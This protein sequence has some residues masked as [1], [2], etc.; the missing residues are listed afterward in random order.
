MEN[1]QGTSKPMRK[2]QSD[3]VPPPRKPFAWPQADRVD[4]EIGCG[5]G[6]HPIAYA[7]AHPDRHIIALDRSAVRLE[8][9]RL[10]L[11]QQSPLTNLSVVR[12][13]ADRFLVHSVPAQS[14]QQIFL[15][16]PNP[17]PK[18]GQ[19]N[20]RWHRMPLMHRM[21]A[22]L[23]PS[24]TLV[25]ATNMPFYA[26]EA[27]HYMEKQWALEVQVDEVFRDTMPFA[28]RTHFEQKYLTRGDPIFHLVFQKSTIQMVEQP[29]D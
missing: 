27:K 9:M 17:Y 13:D 28:P 6:M 15:L 10:A 12:E 3:K 18:E 5:V 25:L 22:C 1:L 29:T 2:F 19:A 23:K 7:K 14:L 21:L 26:E 4:L 11:Q 16:Y 8:K 20:K 24:G